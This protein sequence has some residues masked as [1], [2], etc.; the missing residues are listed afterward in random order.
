M[1]LPGTSQPNS[2]LTLSEVAR[3][4]RVS[5]ATI[6]R[7]TNAGVLMCYR[8]GGNGERRFSSEHL[9]SFLD[10]HEQHRDQAQSI[11]PSV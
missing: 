4:L 1:P 11:A 8:L 2:L 5:K 10:R 9:R 7:W 3:Y 6:R